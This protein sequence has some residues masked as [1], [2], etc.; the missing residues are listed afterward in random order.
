MVKPRIVIYG[1]G[2]YGCDCVRMAQAKGWPVVAAFNRAGSKVGQDIGRL[3]GLD[4]DLGVIVENADIADYQSI[5]ADIAIVTTSD[6]LSHNIE[7]YER[8]L[9][10]GLNVLSH[11]TE[12]YFPSAADPILA[13]KIQRWAE[14]ANVTFT[15]SGIW[16]MSR[17]W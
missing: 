11:G 5:E 12:S 1:T 3:A 17:I 15:A 13:A 7:G 2:R 14:D 6:R 9:T 8:L 16:D 4:K 10:A